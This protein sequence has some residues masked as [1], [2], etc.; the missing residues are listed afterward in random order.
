MADLSQLSSLFKSGITPTDVK[1]ETSVKADTIEII[2]TK[3]YDKAIYVKRLETNIKNNTD[4][5]NKLDE[6]IAKDQALLDQVK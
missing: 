1:T 6:L 3:T 2:D 5:R 4:R